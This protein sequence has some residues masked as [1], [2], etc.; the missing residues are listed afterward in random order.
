L[1]GGV[2]ECGECE[3]DECEESGGEEHHGDLSVVVV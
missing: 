3:V 2:G 1:W